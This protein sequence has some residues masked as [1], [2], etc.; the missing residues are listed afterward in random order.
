MEAFRKHW[1][2]LISGRPGYRFQNHHWR[3]N[4]GTRGFYRACKQLF[5]ILLV[6][7]GV[8][9]LFIPG[10]GSAFIAVG[11]AM[12]SQESRT[13]ARLLDAWELRAR[14]LISAAAMRWRRM[15]LLTRS[16]LVLLLAAVAVGSTWFLYARFMPDVAAVAAG[17]VRSH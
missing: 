17:L 14:R 7:A 6:L 11:A 8:V 12:L 1:Q 15:S 3:F 4:G 13:V 5:S 2:D 16:S 10:P 9:L